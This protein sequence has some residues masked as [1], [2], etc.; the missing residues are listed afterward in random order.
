MRMLTKKI[1]DLNYNNYNPQII[2][3]SK[4]FSMDNKTIN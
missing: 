2:A 4:T 1:K 3:V